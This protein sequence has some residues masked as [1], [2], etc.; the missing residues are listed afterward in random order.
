MKMLNYKYAN[1]MINKGNEKKTATK[2]H[3]K[4]RQRKGKI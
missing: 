2:K 1:I 4:R 3:K